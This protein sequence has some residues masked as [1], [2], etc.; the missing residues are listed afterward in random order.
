MGKY[1]ISIPSSSGGWV[2]WPMMG[3]DIEVIV[4]V[5]VGYKVTISKWWRRSGK[6]GIFHFVLFVIPSAKLRTGFVVKCSF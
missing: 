1:S 3:R 2:P 5:Y 4:I 6:I